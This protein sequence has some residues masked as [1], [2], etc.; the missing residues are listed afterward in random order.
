MDAGYNSS[1]SAGIRVPHFA[2]QFAPR[3]VELYLSHHAV[4]PALYKRVVFVSCEVSYLIT[5]AMFKGKAV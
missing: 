1:S 5:L 4:F 3:S 2:P